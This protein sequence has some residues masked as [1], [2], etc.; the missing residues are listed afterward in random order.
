M[1]TR[2]IK[3]VHGAKV[4]THYGSP[5]PGMSWV[6]INEFIYYSWPGKSYINS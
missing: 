1:R 6:N 4:N 3:I 2:A 5:N